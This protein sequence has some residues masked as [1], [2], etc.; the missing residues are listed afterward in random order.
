MSKVEDRLWSELVRDHASELELAGT[1]RAPRQRR[2]RL[3][4]TPLAIGGLGL[5]GAITAA[6]LALTATTGSPAFA[7][8]ENEDGWV[9]L[10]INELVGVTGA[11]EELAK[12]GIRARVA[13]YEAGCTATHGELV[14]PA[15]TLST[16]PA[17]Q[18]GIVQAVAGQGLAAWRINPSAIPPGDTLSLI[19]TAEDSTNTGSFAFE[20]FGSA[21]YRGSAPACFPPPQNGPPPQ[22]G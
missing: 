19:A 21:L 10:T 8:T 16:P 2:P 6:T 14:R 18:G 4:R 12:L 13:R 9:T 20:S 15:A 1:H 7:V 17:E 11:N 3:R 22:E 5:A